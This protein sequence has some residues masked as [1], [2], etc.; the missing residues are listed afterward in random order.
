M[1]T[2]N[3]STNQTGKA[4][5]PL[6]DALNGAVRRKTEQAYDQG[7]QA[8]SREAAKRRITGA[9][10]SVVAVIVYDLGRKRGWW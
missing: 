4:R 2:A 1:S 6:G 7:Y 3:D 5:S 10:A 8:A 9:V